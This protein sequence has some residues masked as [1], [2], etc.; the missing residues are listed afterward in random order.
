MNTETNNKA[1]TAVDMMIEQ[2][3]RMA[4]LAAAARLGTILE[5][6]TKNT[7]ERIDIYK[8]MIA[9]FE[10]RIQILESGK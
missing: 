3:V 6:G 4:S 10:K 9:V 1:Q 8:G 5:K 2:G 7:A